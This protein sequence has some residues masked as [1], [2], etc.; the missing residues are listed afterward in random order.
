MHWICL[1]LCGICPGVLAE[2]P[3]PAAGRMIGLGVN[4]PLAGS[5]FVAR[6]FP[7]AAAQEKGWYAGFSLHY[8]QVLPGLN[9]RQ[10]GLMHQQERFHYAFYIDQQGDAMYRHDNY[11][12]HTGMHLGPWRLGLGGNLRQH[13]IGNTQSRQLNA[14]LGLSTRI[15]KPWLLHI[16]MQNLVQRTTIDNPGFQSPM[17]SLVMLQFQQKNAQLFASYR[18]AGGSVGDLGIGMQYVFKTRWEIDIGWSTAFRR[19]SLGLHFKHQQLSIRCS[20]MHQLLPG[21]W[22]NSSIDWH[23]RSHP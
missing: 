10:F 12:L 16:G 21:S 14:S 23:G 4:A 5:A 17:Q 9:I 1:V 6:S 2:V 3:L 18:Q 13:R 22:W 15:R 11:S 19:L 8:Y 7:Q 20:L